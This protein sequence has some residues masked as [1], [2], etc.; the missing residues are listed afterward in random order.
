M[1]DA[2]YLRKFIDICLHFLGFNFIPRSLAK[3]EILL[4]TNGNKLGG[5]CGTI[6]STNLILPGQSLSN[7]L[8]RTA[9]SNGPN[10]VLWG[11]PPF[12]FFQVEFE[13]PTLTHCSGLER[14]ALIHRIITGCTP[15]LISSLTITL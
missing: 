5:Y 10:F 3:S 12:V 15:R 7:E 8:T 6:S 2:P 13:F 1:T 9:N 11:R 4:T 14:I